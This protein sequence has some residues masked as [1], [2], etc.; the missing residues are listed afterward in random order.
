MIRYV[1]Y[2]SI[3]IQNLFFFFFL[4][5]VTASYQRLRLRSRLALYEKH[6]ATG[7]VVGWDIGGGVDLPIYASASVFYF[8]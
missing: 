4:A 2:F 8:I 6:L 7:R 3:T 5:T 1:C